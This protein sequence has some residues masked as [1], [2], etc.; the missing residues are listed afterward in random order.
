MGFSR[1]EYWGGLPCPLPG[2]LP[3]PGIEPKSSTMQADSLPSEPPGKS[4]GKPTG[5]PTGKV[6]KGSLPESPSSLDFTKSKK[7]CQATVQLV[8]RQLLSLT[9]KI[10]SPKR[11]K[12]CWETKQV[13]GELEAAMGEIGSSCFGAVMCLQYYFNEQGD[14]VYQLI[15]LDPMGQ[16]ICSAHLAQLF[17]DN[18]YS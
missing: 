7:R 12:P 5:K 1:Q 18:K 14:W 4:P 9:T 3:Y 17:P 2:D 10:Y 6:P 15:N 13:N 11:N 16:Q 8:A